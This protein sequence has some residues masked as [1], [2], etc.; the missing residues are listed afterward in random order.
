M[1]FE[2]PSPRQLDEN[3]QEQVELS[4]E[5]R[6]EEK[7]SSVPP[8]LM[9]IVKKGENPADKSGH[10]YELEDMPIPKKIAP[11]IIEDPTLYVYSK[12]YGTDEYIK[13][14]A[15]DALMHITGESFLHL[16]I[17]RL[18]HELRKRELKLGTGLRGDARLKELSSRLECAVI[19]ERNRKLR[20]LGRD[21]ASALKRDLKLVG[22]HVAKISNS[23][24]DAA[25]LRSDFTHMVTLIRRGAA[26]P[27]FE[28]NDGF[29]ALIRAAFCGD[30]DA[31]CNLLDCNN[32]DPNYENIIGENALIWAAC[33]KGTGKAV[34][35][36]MVG[37]STDVKPPRSRSQTPLI[38]DD[39][40]GDDIFRVP[41]GEQNV[42]NEEAKRKR[43]TITN[44]HTHG[45][46]SNNIESLFNSSIIIDKDEKKDKVTLNPGR[47]YADVNWETSFG[48]T[49]LMAASE[50][51]L[52]ENIVALVELGA[53]I[54]YKTKDR[55]LTALMVATRFGQDAI[56]MYLLDHGA[57]QNAK[58]NQGRDAKEWAKLCGHHKLAN[59]LESQAWRWK[60]AEVRKGAG[61]KLWMKLKLKSKA[62]K[63]VGDWSVH[64]DPTSYTEFYINNITGASQ[65]EM[66]PSILKKRRL[67]WHSKIDST[68]GLKYYY[69]D[70]GETTYDMP[71]ILNKHW[72]SKS[73][74]RSELN[75][76]LKKMTLSDINGK[77]IVP[78]ITKN[79]E[80]INDGVLHNLIQRSKNKGITSI[81]HVGES[82]DGYRGVRRIKAVSKFLKN[83][84]MSITK[85]EWDSRIG[86]VRGRQSALH[87][88]QQATSTY[89]VE[90]FKGLLGIRLGVPYPKDGLPSKGV[91]I[92][93]IHPNTQASDNKQIKIGHWIE[94]INDEYVR[95]LDSRDI[96]Y[97]M[98]KTKRPFLIKFKIPMIVC[99]YCGSNYPHTVCI[100]CD[101]ILC[102]N[103]IVASKHSIKHPNHRCKTIIQV[104]KE[105]TM[106]IPSETGSPSKTLNNEFLPKVSFSQLQ[107]LR[108]S[109]NQ[110]IAAKDVITKV[111]E[112]AHDEWR[113]NGGERYMS[114]EDREKI[115]AEKRRQKRALMDIYNEPPEH[116]YAIW[117]SGMSRHDESRKAIYTVIDAQEKRLSGDPPI[118][119]P[120]AKS[121]GIAATIESNAGDRQG[122][123][124][125]LLQSLT[126]MNPNSMNN[127]EEG[128]GEKTLYSKQFDRLSFYLSTYGMIPLNDM[129]KSGELEQQHSLLPIAFKRA[130]VL[131]QK[132]ER[133]LMVQF[134]EDA[135][136]KPITLSDAQ[137]PRDVEEMLN[138][139]IGVKLFEEFCVEEAID[140]YVRFYLKVK[141]LKK[142]EKLGV[143]VSRLVL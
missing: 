99:D 25:L 115:Q 92:S 122:A 34:L 103:C 67:A 43:T 127:N 110:V 39:E 63:M 14:K 138:D 42:L 33:Q 49:G 132:R 64:I 111:L 106:L 22:A 8:S 121:Y 71:D 44:T 57:I 72:R 27:N 129:L 19:S 50:C 20:K 61:K 143:V 69:N 31:T 3:Y 70:A 73:R 17:K 119:A 86:G 84:I 94:Y 128:D 65:W 11:L 101:A 10:P 105:M 58:D 62:L 123:I 2:L 46:S 85:V 52:M 91:F 59:T 37:L 28:S 30:S 125:C 113:L 26:S 21:K 114:L 9:K 47:S 96:A 23:L 56:A 137:N 79:V 131:E 55:G 109:L 136:D 117:A 98:D 133:T 108:H 24:F 104:G 95:D 81:P 60:Y 48:V 32:I 7:K 68:T 93:K 141:L 124:K 102:M 1:E 126:L 83:D 142:Y 120:L 45:N 139:K 15:H 89:T 130:E 82:I 36:E 90:F 35:M 134:D 13:L 77:T 51:G 74:P 41:I 53:D 88:C 97:K 4:I 118:V 16:G 40:D 66:P 107:T 18:K 29:T 87:R 100:T 12:R 80:E 116:Q 112:P 5:A 140:H 75:S 38:N 6:M 135:E 78:I 76:I 54:N